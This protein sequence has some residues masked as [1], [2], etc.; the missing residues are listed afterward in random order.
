MT[1]NILRGRR[2]RAVV[3]ATVVAGGLVAGVT[4]AVHADQKSSS[5]TPV[6][7]P[8][9]AAPAATTA[10]TEAV[11]EAAATAANCY[12]TYLAYGS[13]GTCVKQLQK[14]IGALSVDGVYGAGTRNRVRAFQADAGLSVDGKVGPQT[15]RK[16]R[17]LGMALG[18]KSGFTVYMC[19]ERSGDFRYSAWNNTG[20]NSLF[21]FYTDPGTYFDG[22]AMRPNRIAKQGGYYGGTYKS[23]KLDVF[24]GTYRPAH[25]TRSV[26]DFS[27]SSLPACI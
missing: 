27:R 24:V 14:K 22:D 15:W 19:K 1:R 9:A 23:V 25:T 21:Y 10:A 20:K 8:A 18:W 5:N 13:R 3:I 4:T 11:T 26:R 2:T 17:T 16:L 6:S 12:S 7:A